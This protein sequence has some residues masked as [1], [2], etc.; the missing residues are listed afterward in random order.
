[1]IHL[2]LLLHKWLKTIIV[3]KRLKNQANACVIKRLLER[4][5]EG[6][7]FRLR[8]M[9]GLSLSE[10]EMEPLLRLILM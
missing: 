4:G 7:K 9:S 8:R 1:M 3:E 6:V 2:I 10:M 5:S